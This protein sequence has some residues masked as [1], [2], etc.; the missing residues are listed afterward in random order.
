MDRDIRSE[1]QLTKPFKLSGS[2]RYD[3]PADHKL[4]GSVIIDRWQTGANVVYLSHEINMINGEEVA[5]NGEGIPGAVELAKKVWE[6]TQRQQEI[7]DQL[8]EENKIKLRENLG[9]NPYYTVR[10]GDTFYSSRDFQD[11]FSQ[12]AS[13]V[14]Y[15]QLTSSDI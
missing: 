3:R 6:A 13:D 8:S 1:G 7:F 4:G 10:D 14:L 9:S 11:L 15:R 5:L 2:V 12:Q